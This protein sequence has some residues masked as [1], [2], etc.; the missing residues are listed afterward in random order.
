MNGWRNATSGR[1]GDQRMNVELE[2]VGLNGGPPLI[3]PK[4]IP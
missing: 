1:A 4:H 3:V 2:P